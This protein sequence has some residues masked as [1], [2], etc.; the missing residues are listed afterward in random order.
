MESVEV[1]FR[2]ALPALIRTQAP[3]SNF[4]GQMSAAALAMFPWAPG[5]I[6]LGL[7]LSSVV[8][9]WKDYLTGGIK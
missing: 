2:K 3:E 5:L 9:A 6:A 4:L 7:S 1:H 8:W